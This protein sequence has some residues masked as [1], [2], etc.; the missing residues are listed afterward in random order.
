MRDVTEQPEGI[1]WGVARLV[2]TDPE[3]VAKSVSELLDDPVAY[4]AMS[5]AVNPYGD[6]RAAER[7]VA[8]IAWLLDGAPR[9]SEFEPTRR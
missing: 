7:S 9:P 6:G 4:A 5:E 2:G 8:G 3:L 1:E